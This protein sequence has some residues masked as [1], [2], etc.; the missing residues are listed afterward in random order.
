MAERNQ[1]IR[2]VM[3]DFSLIW[4][5]ST[6]KFHQKYVTVPPSMKLNPA[7]LYFCQKLRLEGCFQFLP[8]PENSNF[9]SNHFYAQKSRVYY[10]DSFL[11]ESSSTAIQAYWIWPLH[12]L[13]GAAAGWE[14]MINNPSLV[15]DVWS[16]W[17][18][19]MAVRDKTE[20]SAYANNRISALQ[21]WW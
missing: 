21:R 15:F 14:E 7:E 4:W 8:S 13:D 11:L 16:E 19:N 9:G 5:H 18:Q 10:T 2:K 3:F 12:K 1:S 20:L 17:C 6:N